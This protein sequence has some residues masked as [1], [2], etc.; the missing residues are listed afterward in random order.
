MLSGNSEQMVFGSFVWLKVL[1]QDPVLP[2]FYDRFGVVVQK[3][4][5]AEGTDAVFTDS[6]HYIAL[7][8][9]A[10]MREIDCPFFCGHTGVG[11]II[12]SC[13]S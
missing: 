4:S 11:M 10:R 2:F 7:K 3:M 5:L 9:R 1:R 13:G 8:L 12:F 6:I